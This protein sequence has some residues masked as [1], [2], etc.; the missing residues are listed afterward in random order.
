MSYIPLSFQEELSVLAFIVDLA[1]QQLMFKMTGVS[2]ILFIYF[3]FN[4]H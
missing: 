4:V 2:V 3:C 1:P